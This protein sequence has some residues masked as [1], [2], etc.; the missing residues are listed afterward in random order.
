MTS[1]PLRL[2]VNGRTVDLTEVPDD[3][4]LLDTLRWR[5][6]L[7]GTKEGCRTGDCGA[8][9]V[10]VNRDTTLSCLTLSREVAGADVT[11]VEGLATDPVGRAVQRAFVQEGAVQ[12]GYCTPGFVVALTGLLKARTPPPSVEELLE[13]LSGNLC[14]CTGYRAIGRAVRVARESPR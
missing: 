12:C 3:E 13:E 14:R 6:G 10:L 2:K 7:R 11:T 4:R 8:C 1:S 5:M 9:T